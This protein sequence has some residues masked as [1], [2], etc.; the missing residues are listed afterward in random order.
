MDSWC[1]LLCNVAYLCQHFK[2]LLLFISYYALNADNVTRKR[3]RLKERHLCRCDLC[4]VQA[5][6]GRILSFHVC[7]SQVGGV[8]RLFS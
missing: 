6:F 1:C 2:L 3:Y 8:Y 4:F 7:K 5:A